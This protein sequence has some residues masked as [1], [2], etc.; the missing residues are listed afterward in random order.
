MIIAFFRNKRIQLN[1]SVSS[2]AVLIL[3]NLKD[4]DVK[5]IEDA[6]LRKQVEGFIQK[7]KTRNEVG[8][9]QST[10]SFEKVEK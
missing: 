4:D 7:Q 9:G 1:F 10:S 3:R 8:Q 6:K 5:R 2:K